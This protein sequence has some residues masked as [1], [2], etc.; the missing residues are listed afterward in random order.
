MT[1]LCHVSGV[2]ESTSILVSGMITYTIAFYYANVVFGKRRCCCLTHICII[3]F[4]F[5]GWIVA[6]GLGIAMF[7]P[8][9]F[10]GHNTS[11]ASLYAVTP[12]AQ[13]NLTNATFSIVMLQNCILIT[14]FLKDAASVALHGER[15]NKATTFTLPSVVKEIAGIA[16]G[17]HF[18][19]IGA[20][21]GIYIII[22]DKLRRSRESVVSNRL[23]GLGFRLIAIAIVTFF[24][25]TAFTILLFPMN[26]T[27]LEQLLPLAIVALCNPLYIHADL[28]TILQNSQKIEKDHFV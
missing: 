22:A 3:V 6:L 21:A 10:P 15:T 25:W 24:G 13:E 28:S 12:H 2:M 1:S 17:I 20:A 26:M 16:F 9:Q 5:I 14:S 18:L 8:N 4:L 27:Y 23:G 7:S 11:I 19:L